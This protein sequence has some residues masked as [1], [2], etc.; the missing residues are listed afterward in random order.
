MVLKKL[1]EVILLLMLYPTLPLVV[2]ITCHKRVSES[3]NK[4]AR[5]GHNP[6]S[7]EPLPWTNFVETCKG[8]VC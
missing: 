2:H 3:R 7:P 8:N 1:S 4:L 6:T 5:F